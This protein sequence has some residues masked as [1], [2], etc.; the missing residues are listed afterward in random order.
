PNRREALIWCSAMKSNRLND[1]L[2][3]NSDDANDLVTEK[4]N[5]F[6]KLADNLLSSIPLGPHDNPSEENEIF[7][8]IKSAVEN[9]N[10]NMCTLYNRK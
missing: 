4:H 3:E 6:R 9:I 8:M 10:K 1:I 2:D 7:Y 5:S